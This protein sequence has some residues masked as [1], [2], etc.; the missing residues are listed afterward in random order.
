MRQSILFIIS[1]LSNIQP[2]TALSSPMELSSSSLDSSWSPSLG[3]SHS[4]SDWSP[5]PIQQNFNAQWEE[6]EENSNPM[7]HNTSSSD[8]S[9]CSPK[10]GNTILEKWETEN[11]V[12]HPINPENSRPDTP[13]SD[14][15]PP[16]EGK[17]I[18]QWEHWATESSD[19]DIEISHGSGDDDY[20]P[21]RLSPG[22]SNYRPISRENSTQPQNQNDPSIGMSP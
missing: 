14:W 9:Q 6:W 16:P 20:N 13:S 7:Q 2:I 4:S 10:C 3:P 17:Y 11:P 21:S 18:R 19:R 1:Y 22:P 8:W 12:T 15:S 5:P